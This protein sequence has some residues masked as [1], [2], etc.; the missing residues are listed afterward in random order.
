MELLR[1]R[2]KYI[3]MLMGVR[4]VRQVAIL[5]KAEIKMNLTQINTSGSRIV[6]AHSKFG[7]TG[8]K[9]HGIIMA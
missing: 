5:N 3:P 4:T 2:E 8:P 6:G 1:K 7:H 9:H